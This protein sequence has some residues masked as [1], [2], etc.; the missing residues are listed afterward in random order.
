M[1]LSFNEL[2]ISEPILKAL[3]EMGFK[4]PTEV[5]KKS[6]PHALNNEDLI[7][8][9]KTGSGKTAVFGVSILQMIDHTSSH[10]PQGLILT[11]TRE[12]AVQVD[13][14]LKQ[15]SKYLPHRTTAVYGQH[16]IT[17]EIQDLSKGV[18]IVTGTPGRVYDHIRQRNLKTKN[19]KYLV[20]DE[21]DR[22]LDMGFLDQVMRIIKTIPRDRV[23]LLFSAT[24]PDEI[25]KICKNYMN[26]PF[27]IEVESLT[28]TVDTTHQVY[29]R[30][31]SGEKKKQLEQLLLFEHPK[32]CMIFC[33]MRVEVDRVQ[34]FLQNRGYASMPLHGDIPQS[35]RL[36]TINGFKEGKFCIL[37][38]TDVAGRGI[39]I[40]DL[41]LVINYDIPIE[42]D[43]YVHRIGRTGRVGKAGHAI[44]LVTGESIMDLYEIEEHINAMIPL[45][46]LPS[47]QDLENK[48]IL[49][50]EWKQMNLNKAKHL[51]IHRALS[52]Q[53]KIHPKRHE[54][55]RRQ[56]IIKTSDH[57]K[58]KKEIG[59]K[60]PHIHIIK[61]HVSVKPKQIQEQV[62][63]DEKRKKNPLRKVLKSTLEKQ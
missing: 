2:G 51:H 6:I 44:S 58:I 19:I 25:Q 16:S 8:R 36:K 15:I 21:V 30:V 55:V 56:V 23:T 54:K 50:D 32:S 57:N 47:D 33:N 37:V 40:N 27:M 11:P 9:S 26:Q 22:M 39:H 46:E 29:Y 59:N 14:D 24:I 48:K 42:K 60:K 41:S 7:V 10:G 4:K 28:K 49:I 34:K 63:T 31:E 61:R 20:L 43:S 13:K 3:S 52:K 1:E 53:A 17:L 12:L 38:A 18:S 45:A 5:Q 62:K 35:K